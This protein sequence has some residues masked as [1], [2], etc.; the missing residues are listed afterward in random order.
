MHGA[1]VYD[2]FH[3][4]NMANSI[5][6]ANMLTMMLTLSLSLVF[7][8]YFLVIRQIFPQHILP[9]PKVIMKSIM[10]H[11][12][13]LYKRY[14][15]RMQT[16]RSFLYQCVLCSRIFASRKMFTA[17][18]VSGEKVFFFCARIFGNRMWMW[19]KEKPKRMRR[20]MRKKN[21]QTQSVEYKS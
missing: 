6:Q 18:D 7:F 9:E 16:S 21:S 13:Q 3:N 1:K 11:S 20:K 14:Y 12:K 2:E 19:E 17:P 4:I 5:L 10:G 8:F 15:C